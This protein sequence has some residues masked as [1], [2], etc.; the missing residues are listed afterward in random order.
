[1]HDLRRDVLIFKTILK[2]ADLA[3]IGASRVV[4]TQH[5]DVGSC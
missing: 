4:E 1:M 2:T 3:F 5:V